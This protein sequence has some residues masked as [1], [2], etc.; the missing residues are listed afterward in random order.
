[1]IDYPITDSYKLIYAINSLLKWY[2]VKDQP[3]YFLQSFFP[4]SLNIKNAELLTLCSEAQ[5]FS[6][7]ILIDKKASFLNTWFNSLKPCSF[8]NIQHEMCLL[9]HGVQCWWSIAK[10][11]WGMARALKFFPEKNKVVQSEKHAVQEFIFKCFPKKSLYTGNNYQSCIT[12]K[13]SSRRKGIHSVKQGLHLF[14]I[15]SYKLFSFHHRPY[16]VKAA[17]K[18]M[19]DAVSLW[20]KA[21]KL[22]WRPTKTALREPQSDEPQQ[23]VGQSSDAPQQGN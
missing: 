1:M 8:Y 2:I 7:L 17:L 22:T 16:F 12:Q 23:R 18:E 3:S 15:H 21:L 4:R 5:M 9:Y 10:Q 13:C 19:E 14:S 11:W 20:N 6:V